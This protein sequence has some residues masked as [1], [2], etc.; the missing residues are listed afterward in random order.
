MRIHAAAVVGFIV[1]CTPL[2]ARGQAYLDDPGSLS[3]NAAYTYAPSGKLVGSL[4]DVPA[5]D[6]FIHIWTPGIDYTTPITG[7]QLE[8]ELTLVAVKLG[9]DDF[10]HQPAPGPYD[11]GDLHFTPTDFKAGVRYQI[12]PIEPYLG[13]SFSVHGS[14]PTHDYPTTGYV[15]PGHH[16][17]ALYLG[18]SVARTFDP[19]LPDL[20]FHGEYTYA[21]RERVDFNDETSEL[22]RN[23]SDISGGLGYFLPANFTIGAALFVHISHGGLDLDNINFVTEAQLQFHDQ[24]L[25]E[26]FTL[27]GGDLTYTVNDRMDITGLF[28]LF[29]KDLFLD[30]QNTRNSNLYGLSVSYRVF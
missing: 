27:V 14:V 16:L 18:T 29:A 10:T 12:K 11:D 5:T 25:D 22:G 6:M 15:A 28:R 8:T 2:V 1:V 7:L 30:S 13:L 9:E 23:F 26:D 21:I 4:T 20:F 3:V 17:K 24:L 19:L